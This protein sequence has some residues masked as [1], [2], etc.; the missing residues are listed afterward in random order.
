MTNNM[1]FLS[2]TEPC[3]RTQQHANTYAHYVRTLS[4]LSYMNLSCGLRRELKMYWG[5]KGMIP[6]PMKLEKVCSGVLL[7]SSNTSFSKPA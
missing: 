5:D 3:K 4:M 7:L 1:Q 2:R 6:F